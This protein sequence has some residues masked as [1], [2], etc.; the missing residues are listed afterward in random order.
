MTGA[1]PERSCPEQGREP[2]VILY[3]DDD[4]DFLE[5]VKII[6]ERNGQFR[7]DTT[8]S[9]KEALVR[10]KNGGYDL[11][12]SDYR[13]IRMD[14]IALLK[15]VREI[16]PSLP[17]ILF[18]GMV[19]YEIVEEALRCG[20]TLHLNKEGDSAEQF[21]RLEEGIRQVISDR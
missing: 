5:V 1:V 21:R 16:D 12:L 4:P 17:F 2:V 15:G 11:V 7:V 19:D 10:L 3:V 13:M 9:G 8:T 20:A 18:T 14:G 6:L